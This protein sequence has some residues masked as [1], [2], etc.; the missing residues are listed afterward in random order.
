MFDRIFARLERGGDVYVVLNTELGWA[1]ADDFKRTAQLLE[2]GLGYAD[3]ELKDWQDYSLPHR[4]SITKGRIKAWL[5]TI[6]IEIN[7]NEFTDHFFLTSN[8]A[9]DGC[10]GGS[11]RCTA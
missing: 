5:K 4:I 7:E 8:A 2:G 6:G 11:S 3:I 1:L 9:N 10:R